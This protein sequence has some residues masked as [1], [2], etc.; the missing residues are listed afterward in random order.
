MGLCF[1]GLFNQDKLL[2]FQMEVKM[3]NLFLTELPH[4][5]TFNKEIQKIRE[6]F[7]LE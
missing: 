1:L 6:W 2:E 3:T 4:S 7:I 5:Q